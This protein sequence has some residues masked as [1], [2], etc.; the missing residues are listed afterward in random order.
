[1][2]LLLTVPRLARW[3]AA[4]RVLAIATLLGVLVTLWLPTE[5]PWANVPLLDD[6]LRRWNDVAGAGGES[7]PLAAPAQVLAFAG[8]ACL[9][10][11]AVHANWDRE[12]AESVAGLADPS[13]ATTS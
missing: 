1:V 2:F 10:A 13:S 9:L 4:R 8:L 3:A 6:V 7:L 5:W 11:A 12:P